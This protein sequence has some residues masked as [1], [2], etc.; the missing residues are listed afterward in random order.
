MILLLGLT[1]W[2]SGEDVRLKASSDSSP[3]RGETFRASPGA[4]ARKT[5]PFRTN[6]YDMFVYCII[7]Y[8]YIVFILWQIYIYI[9]YI[10]IFLGMLLSC[11]AKNW[12]CFRSDECLLVRWI[13]FS[14]N[15][16][17]KPMYFSDQ[18]GFFPD[19]FSSKPIQKKNSSWIGTS[20][21]CLFKRWKSPSARWGWWVDHSV[22]LPNKK[23]RKHYGL[24]YI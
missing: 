3:S 16:Y 13:G 8:M 6:L 18:I 17:G 2:L 7:L 12:T 21:C 11:L 9:Q 1:P 10:N 22:Q 20:P 19:I 15:T 24:W 4:L 5:D 14:R 23:W